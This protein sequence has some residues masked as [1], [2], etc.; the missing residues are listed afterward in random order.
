ME[1]GKKIPQNILNEVKKISDD[2]TINLNWEDG[3]LCMI[4][5]QR[6]MH[7]RRS[8]DQEEK[9]DII[10]IQTLNAKMYS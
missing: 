8:I 10:N 5:N 4:N 9:R 3:D 2:L 1:N 6:F 7:G